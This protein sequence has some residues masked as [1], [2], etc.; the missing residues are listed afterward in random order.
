MKYISAYAILLMTVFLWSCGT[1]KEKNIVYIVDDDGNAIGE[2]IYLEDGVSISRV[3]YPGTTEVEHEIYFKN[4]KSHGTHKNYYKNGNLK[5]IRYYLDG[6]PIRYDTGYHNNGT[7]SLLAGFKG[8]HVNGE[9][10]RYDSLGRTEQKMWF[11]K[12]SMVYYERYIYEKET[13]IDTGYYFKPYIEVGKDTF[14]VGDTIAVYFLLPYTPERYIRDSFYLTFDIFERDT[15]VRTLRWHDQFDRPKIYMDY[16]VDKP[17]EWTIFCYLDYYVTT[18]A[19][20]I[21]QFGYT[22]KDIYV[23]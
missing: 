14:N 20:D 21:E 7:I 6:I 16:I 15:T 3:F 10:L 5:G 19:A 9:V 8:G 13:I 12:D 1:E 2:E 23:K 4:G 22:G 17:G 18:S 11:H